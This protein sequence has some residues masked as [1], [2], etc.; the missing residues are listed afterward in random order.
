MDLSQDPEIFFNISV[1]DLTNP[2]VVKNSYSSA[3]VIEGTP[4][5]NQIFGHFWNLER[6]QNGDN[7][8]ISTGF[9]ASQKTPFTVYINGEIYESGYVKLDNVKKNGNKIEYSCTLYGGLG[10]FLY[11]LSFDDAGEQLKLSDL[12]YMEGGDGSEFDFTINR[13]A[14]EDA[15]LNYGVYAGPSYMWH[16]I[17]FAPCY[18]GFPDDFSAD[19]CL[20]NFSGSALWT[21]TT[22]DGTTYTPSNGYG[23]GTL[24]EKISE[25]GTRDL[26]SY[27]QRPILRMKEVVN[28]CATYAQKYGYTVEF[29]NTFFKSDNPYWNNTWITLPMLNE[30]TI[31]GNGDE[32]GA[33]STATLNYR[34]AMNFYDVAYLMDVSPD[35]PVGTSRVELKFTPSLSAT[36]YSLP[37]IDPI[38]NDILYTSTMFDDGK[39]YAGWAIQLLALDGTG[40]TS[41]IIAGSDVAWLTSKR[42]EDYLSL[43]ETSFVPQYAGTNYFNSFGWFIPKGNGKYAWSKEITLSMEIPSRTAGF[44]IHIVPYSNRSNGEGRGRLYISTTLSE[45]VASGAGINT[46]SVNNT[47]SE[48]LSGHT[49][50]SYRSNDNAGYTGAK[51]S[52][53]VLLN[54]EYTP[55]D[56]LLSYCKLFGLYLW[57]KPNEKIIHIDTRNTFYQTGVTEDLEYL[58]DR[59]QDIT[60]TPLT[61]DSKWYDMKLEGAEGHF[62]E[63]YQN[64]YG[65]N[66]GIQKID[67]GYN[68]NADAKDLFEG[69]VFRCAVEG[70]QQGRYYVAPAAFAPSY[71]MPYYVLQGFKY[72]LYNGTG[73]TEVD[74]SKAVYSNPTPLGNR[75]FYDNFSKAQFEDAEGKGIDGKNVLLFFRGMREMVNSGNTRIPY[76]ITD[77]ISDMGRLNDGQPCWLYTESEYDSGGTKIAK[78]TYYLPEFGRYILNEYNGYIRYSLDF[79]QPRELFIPDAV[80]R[81]TGTLYYNFWK[82]YIEDMYSVNSRVLD[83]Y[84]LVE[85]NPNPEWLRKFYWFDNSIWRLNAITDWNL[86]KT[87]PTLL[88]FVKVQDRANYTLNDISGDGYL[89]LILSQYTVGPTGATITGTIIADSSWYLEYDSR[90]RVS[91]DSGDG[92]FVVAITVPETTGTTEDSF[93]IVL[94]GNETQVSRTIVREGFQF[95][96]VPEPQKFGC[97]GIT[98]TLTITSNGPWFL[99]EYQVTAGGQ[100]TDSFLTYSQTAGTGNSVVTYTAT[101]STLDVGRETS[102]VAYSNA[103]MTRPYSA[104][105]YIYQDGCGTFTVTPGTPIS[106]SAD[107]GDTVYSEDIDNTYGYWYVQFDDSII[108]DSSLMKDY[109][110]YF[111]TGT[112]TFKIA[113]NTT[114]TQRTTFIVYKQ[115]RTILKIITIYQ[116]A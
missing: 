56:Y 4:N 89:N 100:Y 81:E 54:T 12:T 25:W 30:L 74:M 58:I 51:L 43:N 20:I 94:F 111:N 9:N 106:V 115:N 73:S 62:Y 7:T 53:Q 41:N 6:I 116:E 44:A 105:T 27:L 38:E 50:T 65:R 64:T 75:L 59:G 31:E 14:V 37:H 2:T 22:V 102:I 93:F 48:L 114:G 112:H 66:Y 40:Y 29:D 33:P 79:G 108:I 5:N 32:E 47:A 101:A 68:F 88:Q 109:Q 21:S 103:A 77:D 86:S 52:K 97:S 8:N 3:L 42:G 18:N 104:N 19:K 110:Y 113:P 84:C 96:M 60:I 10:D 85:N 55:A 71:E 36:T 26:R 13:Q 76:Y 70:L 39:T 16:Y 92:D 35:V 61:F 11:C 95:Y 28:A 99:K 49:F 15:W 82:R 98:G 45:Y 107:P 17:N 80:T 63:K 46:V 24:P 90:L 91:E 34:R 72:N 57:K 78:K 1:D 67:T 83:C 87:Q 69:N 23:L